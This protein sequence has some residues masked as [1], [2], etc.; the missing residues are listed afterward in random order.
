MEPSPEK[1]LRR[2]SQ[3]IVLVGMMGAGKSTVG[4]RLAARLGRPF[5]DA[6][7]EIEAAA[8]MT[9][10]E[11]FE[12]YGEPYFRDGERRVIQRLLAGPPIVLAT[13]G[14]AFAQDDTREA[15][16]DAALAVW[17]DVP[18]QTLVERVSRRNHRPLL[19]GRDAAQVLTEL[20]DKRGPAYAQAQLRV[21]SA[22]GPH[23]RVVDAILAALAE[24]GVP[25]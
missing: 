6:D 9:I 25:Q 24:S 10:A 2:N 4:R 5:A 12:R 23:D 16:L 19:H 15:I 13:G 18:L 14:G 3:S 7:D 17:I 11:I 20:L 8:G 21:A 1:S 22:Q